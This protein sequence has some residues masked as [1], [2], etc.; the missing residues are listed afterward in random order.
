MNE[1]IPPHRLEFYY[2]SPEQ[3]SLSAQDIINQINQEELDEVYNAIREVS[4]G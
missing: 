4:H 3:P 1:Q 2:D